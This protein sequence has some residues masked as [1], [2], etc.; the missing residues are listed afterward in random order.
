VA[1]RF[2]RQLL[3]LG[4]DAYIAHMI[5]QQIFGP[6][7][8]MLLA[9][10]PRDNLIV[11]SCLEFFEYVKK[12]GAKELIR[13]L[14]QNYR[15]KLVALSEIET[16]EELI[17]RYDRTAG[18]TAGSEYF[19]NDVDDVARAAPN[20]QARMM[21]PIQIDPA[22][23]EYWSKLSD[24]EDDP[25]TSTAKKQAQP[26]G[27]APSKLLV[28][29]ESDDDVDENTD[30]EAL[31]STAPSGEPSEEPS[32]KLQPA[33]SEPAI[34]E[35]TQTA[36]SEESLAIPPTQSSASAASGQGISP[37]AG[38]DKGAESPNTPASAAAAAANSV[39]P[40]ER[41]SEKRR[42]EE[43]DDELGRLMQN[44]RRNSSSASSN[45]SST[46]S[47]VAKRKRTFSGASTG[48]QKIAISIS[49]ALLTSAAVGSED[50]S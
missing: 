27:P 40:P 48:S 28:D 22:E 1:I 11:S 17:A 8:D 39:A 14:V 32:A 30:P 19:L 18:F 10:M 3:G 35:N 38:D 9:S 4:D 23:E 42:R 21:E 41:L 2:F 24:D 37:D 20:P 43:D 49:P 31:P 15:D 26:N 16:F 29:Y 34:S 25:T 46:T 36:D 6:I 45:A 13:H 33:G 50:E 12:E 5:E 44:K 47:S 7:L